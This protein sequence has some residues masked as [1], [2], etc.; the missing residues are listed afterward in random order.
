MIH[1]FKLKVLSPYDVKRHK[2]NLSYFVRHGVKITFLKNYIYIHMDTNHA[3]SVLLN[4][5][6]YY[7]KNDRLSCNERA[8]NWLSTYRQ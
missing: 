3:Y 8:A 2:Q 5:L 6:F 4:L 1:T 7:Q